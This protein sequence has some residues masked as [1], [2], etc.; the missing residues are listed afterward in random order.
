MTEGVRATY[1]QAHRRIGERRKTSAE[2]N[3][4]LETAVV[5]KMMRL[6]EFPLCE[7]RCTWGLGLLGLSESNICA[8]DHESRQ[9]GPFEGYKDGG[10]CVGSKLFIALSPQA[11]ERIIPSAGDS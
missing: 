10:D 3:L 2:S 9:T 8:C 5:G 7:R 4:P 1:E 6:A 11:L